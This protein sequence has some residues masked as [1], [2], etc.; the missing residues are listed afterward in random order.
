MVRE[1][2]T[3]LLVSGSRSIAVFI[4]SMV[5]LSGKMITIG[6]KLGWTSAG[7]VSDNNGVVVAR[8]VDVVL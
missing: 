6:F 7:V 3:V 2:L 1:A 8:T 4:S 5:T